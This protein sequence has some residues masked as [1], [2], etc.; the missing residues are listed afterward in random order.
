MQ[1]TAK[2]C[3][4][5]LIEKNALKF[6]NHCLCGFNNIVSIFLPL[7]FL[8]N[9][10]KKTTQLGA[11]LFKKVAVSNAGKRLVFYARSV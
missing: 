5:I 11:C 9:F 3:Y 10:T 2:A 4:Y 6:E 7:E 8:T 1:A